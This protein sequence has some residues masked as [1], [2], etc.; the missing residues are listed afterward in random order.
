MRTL[1]YRARL[2][3]TFASEKQ[4]APALKLRNS[5]SSAAVCIVAS[6]RRYAVVIQAARGRHL[7]QG[8]APMNHVYPNKNVPPGSGTFL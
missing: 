6:S 3:T 8:K 7:L 2:D 4:C 1:R 5:I